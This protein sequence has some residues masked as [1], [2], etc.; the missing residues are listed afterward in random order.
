[1]NEHMILSNI[2]PFM[3]QVFSL[4]CRTYKCW[5]LGIQIH[6]IPP[7]KGHV[8]T[9]FQRKKLVTLGIENTD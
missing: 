6:T 4:S 5:G 2:Q 3:K 8:V 1:M 7:S 9:L